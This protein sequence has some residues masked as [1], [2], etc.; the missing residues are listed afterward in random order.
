TDVSGSGTNTALTFVGHYDYLKLDLINWDSANGH[1]K[2]SNYF[3]FA[4]SSD[5]GVD[6]KAL[7]GSGFNIEGL[8][9]A[10][11]STTT[12]YVCF[13][14]PIVPATNRV[15]ALI[16]P[17]TNFA[18]LAS[19]SF[20]NPGAAGFGA[21][22]ELNLGGRAFRSIE[23]NGDG[24]LIVC[25]PPGVASGTPPSDFRMFTWTGSPANAPLERAASLTNLIVEGIVELPPGPLTSSS[26]VQLISDNG[27]TVY[28]DDTIEAKQLPYPGFK[29]FRS[30]WVTLGPVVTSQ[31]AI[32][33]VH[34]SSGLCSITW[35]SVAGLTYRVQSKNALSDP[36]WADVPGDVAATDALA[37]KA[38][39]MLSTGQRFFR[40]IIP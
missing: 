21:P 23:G 16:V 15:K 20:T 29:K 8:T 25:G 3:G 11:G 14:A 35:Y 33:E 26:T 7:D 36:A 37:T 10:P 1:G 27:I 28:Y 13:R 30:D 6:P 22:I 34:S 9:M 40:V 38:V 12:A 17:V 5:P 4:G 24:Y 31:P 39:G 18:A 2:G 32:K 19:G